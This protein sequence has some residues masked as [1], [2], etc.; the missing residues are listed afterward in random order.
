[1]IIE[2]FYRIPWWKPLV[3]PRQ[4]LRILIIFSRNERRNILG[5]VSSIVSGKAFEHSSRKASR[6]CKNILS[7]RLLLL[8]VTLQNPAKHVRWRLWLKS[9]GQNMKSFHFDGLELYFFLTVIWLPHGQLWRWFSR[10]QPHQP[11][12]NHCIWT[13]LTQRPP[14]AS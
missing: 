14:G 12:V 9:S 3:M 4:M 5:S 6:C 8:L 10:G 11:D 13:I 7:Q 2:W 1:M